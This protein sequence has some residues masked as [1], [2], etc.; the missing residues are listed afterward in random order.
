MNVWLLDAELGDSIAKLTWVGGVATDS[1]RESLRILSHIAHKDSG[2]AKDV[3]HLRWFA[4]GVGRNEE[5]VLRQLLRLALIDPDLARNVVTTGWF[6]ADV[7]E[8]DLQ[9]LFALRELASFDLRLARTATTLTW[10]ADELTRDQF[11]ALWALR[12]LGQ[13]DAGLAFEIV[14]S[15]SLWSPR[16]V[17]GSARSLRAL[18]E[19]HPQLFEALAAKTWFA[20]GLSRQDAAFLSTLSSTVEWPELHADLMEQ[21][22]MRLRTIDVPLGGQVDV[23]LFSN[24]PIDPSDPLLGDFANAIWAG[25]HFMRVPFPDRDFVVLFAD[26]HSTGAFNFGS[27][28]VVD[29]QEGSDPLHPH[30][31]FH[32]TAH[33]YMYVGL[34]NTW[35]VEGGANFLATI[36]LAHFGIRDLDSW[37]R[38]VEQ[39][40]RE[41]CMRDPGLA[42]IQDIIDFQRDSGERHPCN[43]SFGS[44]FLY[45]LRAAMG[46]DAIAAALGEIYK[47]GRETYRSLPEET[48]YETML[49][50]TPDSQKEGFQNTYRE[51]HGGPFVASFVDAESE[52]LVP[53]ALQ[54]ELDELLPWFGRPLDEIHSS[55]LAAIV[56][57]WQ[58]N[59]RLGLALAKATWV[60]DG[61]NH[62]EAITLNG[63]YEIATADS[64]LTD[65]IANSPW[66]KDGVVFWERKAIEAIAQ[67]ALHA[68]NDAKRVAQYRWVGDGITN[69]ERLLLEFL[70]TLSIT[71]Q[72]AGRPTPSFDWM[73]DGMTNA[74][75]RLLVQLRRILEQHPL[76]CLDVLALPWVSNGPATQHSE[77]RAV[78]GLAQL[79]EADTQLAT[80]VIQTEW[81]LDELHTFE[82]SALGEIGRVA[83]V[84]IQDARQILKSSWFRDG[85]DRD[86]VQR[87]RD[88]PS[89]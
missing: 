76:F 55:A 37:P 82:A 87:L 59:P 1:R 32:E 54:G 62:G 79:A 28:V 43:Y 84:D 53:N 12:E 13:V 68:P 16:L 41:G 52:V 30:T 65:R 58:L 2:L 73:I 38:S 36:G 33:H 26:G 17:A 31:V 56:N 44:H 78:K 60:I 83:L 80:E 70:A 6:S 3:V 63:L 29:R 34:G 15:S 40:V 81:A 20:D 25:E 61:V 4:D 39:S 69:E 9:A 11:E 7:T 77:T 45:E 49:K 24:K 57:V 85:I 89:N 75:H 71:T 66:T 50:N 74:E 10:F 35:L 51:L 48:I 47:G 86:D 8:I 23:W 64:D 14:D 27:H 72:S 19:E 88:Y 5:P 18:R 21:H 46:H 42:T 67:L 22:Y